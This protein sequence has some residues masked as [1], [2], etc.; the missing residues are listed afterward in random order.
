MTAELFGDWGKLRNLG[1]NLEKRLQAELRKA[2]LKSALLLVREIKEGIKSQAPGGVAFAP[3]AESTV[4]HKGSSKALI[5]TGFLVNAITQ[6]IMKGGTQAFVGL[7]RTAM[8]PKG[9]NAA[10]IGAIMEF[11]AT[12]KMKNGA[13]VVIPARPFLHPVMEK[14]RKTI[15]GYYNDALKAVFRV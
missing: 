2:T 4:A 10:N 12:I 3:L 6:K 7:L 9:Q 8:G 14:H 15:Q 1:Q 13:T 5:D 11:G